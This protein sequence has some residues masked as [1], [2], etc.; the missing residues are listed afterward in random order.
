MPKVDDLALEV[1]R[2]IY[3]YISNYPGLHERELSR[4][5]QIPL[6]TLDYH[7][8]YL[9]KRNLI[10]VRSDGRYSRYYIVG[11][12]GVVEKKILGILRQKTTRKIVLFLLLNPNSTHRVICNHLNLAPSTTS[13][14]LGNLVNLEVLIRKQKGRE[15][16]FSVCNPETISDLLITYRKSFL[17]KAVDQFIDV[18]FELNPKYVRKK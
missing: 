2:K 5:L 11:S 4:T 10:M 8:H 14:H 18:W 7:L 1:R 12:M 13:F 15:S 16:L 3:R 6:G 9:K 17:D